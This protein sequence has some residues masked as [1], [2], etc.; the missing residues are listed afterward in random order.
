METPI[1]TTPAN[2]VGMGNPVAP[3]ETGEIGSG[4]TFMVNKQKDKSKKRKMKSLKDFLKDK[5]NG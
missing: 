4:D 3:G 2:T 5:K 1:F